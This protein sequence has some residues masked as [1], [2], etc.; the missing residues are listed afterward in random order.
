MFRPAM[1]V[2]ARSVC[3][4]PALLSPA[5]L[6]G[7]KTTPLVYLAMMMM[8]PLRLHEAPHLA[9]IVLLLHLSLTEC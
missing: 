2:R 7:R 5:V 1:Y 6:I 8:L 3:T 9:Q 4:D